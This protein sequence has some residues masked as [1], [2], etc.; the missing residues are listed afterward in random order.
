VIC[1]DEPGVLAKVTNTISG[2][3]VNIQKADIRTSS[4]MVGT[5]DF[6]L[7]LQSLTQLQAVIGKLESIPSVVRVERRNVLKSTK[8]TKST[9]SS[10]TSKTKTKKGKSK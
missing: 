6:E 4:D 2:A 8:S 1:R 10:K 5:L 7:G 3:G 9:K